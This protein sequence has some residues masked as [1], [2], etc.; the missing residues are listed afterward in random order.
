MPARWLPPGGLNARTLRDE[1]AAWGQSL[2][3]ASV[4]LRLADRQRCRSLPVVHGE[5]VTF[6]SVAQAASVSQSWLYR[7][8]DLRAEIDR[9][10]KTGTAATATIASA[11][12]ASTDSLRRRLEA[13]LDEIQRRKAEHRQLREEG[14]RRF[15]QQRTDGLR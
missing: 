8:P 10:R 7:Q 14:A 9:L 5:S 1:T 2:L 13:T 4:K 15:G 6:T 3:A 11:Q 12:R